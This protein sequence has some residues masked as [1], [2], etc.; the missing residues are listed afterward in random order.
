[1]VQNHTT[2]YRALQ[3]WYRGWK[4]GAHGGGLNDGEKKDADICRGYEAGRAAASAA[5]AAERDRLGVDGKE[6]ARGVLR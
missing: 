5:W 6:I 2:E 3:S 4:R 1:M